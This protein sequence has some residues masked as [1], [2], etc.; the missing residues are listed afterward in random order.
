[1][2]DFFVWFIALIIP[3]LIIFITYIKS[4]SAYQR[5]LF[6]IKVNSVLNYII[7]IFCVIFILFVKF[8]PYILAFNYVI[9]TYMRMICYIDLSDIIPDGSLLLMEGENSNAHKFKKPAFPYY[10]GSDMSGPSTGIKRGAEELNSSINTVYTRDSGAKISS[11]NPKDWG[12]NVYH[13]FGGEYHNYGHHCL[14]MANLLE[15]HSK[16]HGRVLVCTAFDV[17]NPFLSHS[18]TEFFDSF[19]E[20]RK[21]PCAPMSDKI[22]NTEELR[23]LFRSQ[24]FKKTEDE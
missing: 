14:Q 10:Q 2:M 21:I 23:K 1:M 20:A 24:W 19:T 8:F 13:D 18:A 3:G 22:A 15:Y 9:F 11:R 6:F 16:V 7:A 4:L 5:F 12:I 17:M